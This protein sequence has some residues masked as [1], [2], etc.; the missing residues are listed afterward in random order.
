MTNLT[1]IQNWDIFNTRSSLIPNSQKFYTEFIRNFVKKEELY[2]NS[3]KKGY[4]NES[5]KKII[6]SILEKTN[7]LEQDTIGVII[8]FMFDNPK[9]HI[10]NIIDGYNNMFTTYKTDCKMLF[11][12]YRKCENL[13]ESEIEEIDE[14]E[15]EIKNKIIFLEDEYYFFKKIKY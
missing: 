12:Q 2:S 3:Y 7:R 9:S 10:K 13:I 1:D 6:S 14:Y 15:D 5:E 4:K 11:L 8:S